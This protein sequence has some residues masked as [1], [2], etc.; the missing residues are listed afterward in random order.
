MDEP[1]K[2]D[3]QWK[4][5]GWFLCTKCSVY[6]NSQDRVQISGCR[7]LEGGEWLLM[8]KAS[9]LGVMTLLLNETVMASRRSGILTSEATLC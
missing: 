6:A 5:P 9:L 3:G 2:H 4:K 1:R 7:G 8:G